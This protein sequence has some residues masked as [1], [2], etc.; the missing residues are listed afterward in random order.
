VKESQQ[1]GGQTV[2][3]YRDGRRE[4]IFPTGQRQITHRDGTEE[5]IFVSGQKQ[6]EYPDGKKVTVFS[7]GQQK[8]EYPDGKKVTVHADGQ[9]QTTLPDGTEVTVFADD[10][11]ARD[12]GK[13]Y[14]TEKTTF[15]DGRKKVLWT[16]GNID[17]NY[18]DGTKETV[19]PSGEKQT[20][21]PDGTT[22]IV[23]AKGLHIPAVLQPSRSPC[24]SDYHDCDSRA[25]QA[26]GG[27]YW[28]SVEQL[29]EHLAAPFRGD[30]EKVARVMFR[31]I[32]DN[33]AYDVQRLRR[34]NMPGYSSGDSQTAE[35]V[36]RT[37]RAV[38]EGY[39]R[40][41]CDM[42]D[43]VGV[44]CKY[45]G[46]DA[47]GGE[48]DREPEGHGW[49]ALSFDG[50][51]SWHL[52][53][54]CWAAG[55]TSGGSGATLSRQTSTDTLARA[56]S[57]AF[58]RRF[59]KKWWCTAPQHFVE[60]HLPK[61]RGDQLLERPVSKADWARMR[62]TAWTPTT[63]TAM[64]DGDEVLAPSTGVLRRGQR[65]EFRIFLAED[66][67]STLRLCWNNSWGDEAAETLR[68]QRG[69]GGY[70]HSLT[71]QARSSGTVT[72][73]KQGPT[74]QTSTGTTTGYNGLA[75]WKVE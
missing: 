59:T 34:M 15:P 18:P 6:I 53:D 36:M 8:T 54:V 4:V 65:V 35:T 2:R 57:S 49:N 38:C 43:A 33:I 9:R 55:S 26:Q 68:S 44:P 42:C 25:L 66:S 50:S 1:G 74:R 41:L 56:S 70:V 32:A 20:T 73:H 21:F 30:M 46:G 31:W 40:L 17:M 5:T 24:S 10:G 16:N 72:V 11:T 52:C 64:N 22:E 67:P 47:R 13:S 71:V 12:D 58:T 14:T 19:L 7:D 39:S 3:E 45:V 28:R 27:R 48:D 29:A 51:R 37:G 23:T 62:D 63:F 69:R 60:R 75:E 61:D